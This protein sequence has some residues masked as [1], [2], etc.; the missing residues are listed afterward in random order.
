MVAM[1][2][3]GAL[4]LLAL[5]LHPCTASVTVYYQPAQSQLMVQAAMATLTAPGSHYTGLPAY[6]PVILQPPAPPGPSALP[7]QFGIALQSAVPPAASIPLNGSF[8]G[9]SVEMSVANQVC[10]YPK[11]YHRRSA[12]PIQL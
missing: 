5:T 3:R 11:L 12:L 6:N 1:D 10:E 7:T 8:M 2:Y 9:F 4:L